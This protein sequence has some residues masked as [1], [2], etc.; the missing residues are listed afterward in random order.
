MLKFFK[1][2]LG[3]ILIIVVLA[4]IG[5]YFLFFRKPSVLPETTAAKRGTIVQEVSVTG[6]IKPAE[7]VSLAFEKGGKV[8]MVGASVGDRVNQG[9]IIVR[10]ES[11]ELIGQL[12][13][14]EASVETEQAELDELKKGTRPEEIALYEAKVTSVK[15]ALDSAKKNLVDKLQDAYTKS[16]DAVRGKIDQFFDNP[17]GASPQL[18]FSAANEINIEN[19]RVSVESALNLWNSS[20]NQL[21]VASDLD[22]YAN[23][24]GKNLNQVKSFLDDIA[25]AVNN[26][27]PSTSLSQTTIDSWKTDVST[28]RTNV[29]T[30]IT[31]L[32]TAKEKFKTAETSLSE[33]ENELVL[34]KAG[35]TA[36]QIAAQE[37]QLKQAE[38][39]VQTTQA[40]IA[41]NLLVSPINGIV[42]KQDAKVGEIV[43]ANASIVS[44]IS[45]NNFSA[46]GGPA[47][48]W[49]I[50]ANIPEADIAKVSVG[51]NARLTLDA[52][53]DSVVFNAKVVKIDPAE[54]VIEGVATYKTTLQFEHEDGRIKSGMTANVDIVSGKHENVIVIPQRAVVNKNGEQS[55]RVLEG[56]EIKEYPVKTGLRGSD[57]NIEITEGLKEGQQVVTFIQGT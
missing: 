7:E 47:F 54:T 51:N 21:T 42:T 45:E 55:V 52:Y 14:M 12:K 11:G 8:A 26:L 39:K 23:E 36:E 31:N 13:E 38:A 16:D 15:V 41:K 27:T 10:L 17:R 2:P 48:G 20:L 4:G 33:A 19:G 35:S 9:Q 24:A 37:A 43:A 30:A 50:E 3:I 53:G 29:Y 32:T 22:F 18:K 25:L 1:R 6:Q 49:E 34:E 44:V 28:A 46:N 5:I 57:G 56:E 40:Q